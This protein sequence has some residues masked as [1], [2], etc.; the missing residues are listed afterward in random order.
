V[1]KSKSAAVAEVLGEM[2]V[3]AVGNHCVS[4]VNYGKIA[5]V[6]ES[7][8]KLMNKKHIIAVNGEKMRLSE[9]NGYTIIIEG[10]I[11]SIEYLT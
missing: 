6:K 9:F 7:S 2:T 8:V 10:K 5:D 11:L 4:V 3:T 1:R